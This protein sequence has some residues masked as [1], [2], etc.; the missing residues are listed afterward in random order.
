VMVA[1]ESEA[2][3]VM[4]DDFYTAQAG[5]SAGTGTETNQEACR[6]LSSSLSRIARDATD[7]SFL[8]VEVLKG[9]ASRDIAQS[10]GVTKYP[11]YQYYKVSKP[12]LDDDLISSRRDDLLFLRVCH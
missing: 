10:L 11:T 12:Q 9:G 7:V 2:E 5:G 3:C 8:K 4:S 6:L 1:I